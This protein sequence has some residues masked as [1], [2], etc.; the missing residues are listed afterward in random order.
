LEHHNAKIDAIRP[1]KT[2]EA[3]GEKL[4][5]ARNYAGRDWQCA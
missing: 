3:A 2:E 4:A 1:M 5:L